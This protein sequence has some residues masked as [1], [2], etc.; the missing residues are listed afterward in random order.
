[1]LAIL[2]A[3]ALVPV[4]AIA[5]T[6]GVHVMPSSWF[7]AAF[8]GAGG[9]LT[10]IAAV[11]LSI[12]AA[13]QRDGRAVLLSLAFSVMATGLLVHAFATP[14][15]LVGMNGLVQLAGA[16]NL[17][18]GGVILAASALPALRR[19]VRV[20]PLLR[21]QV[22]VV[23]ALAGTAGAIAL[24]TRTCPRVPSPRSLP[25]HLVF[26]TGAPLLGR[27]RV[28]RRRA[29]SCSPAALATCSSAS[30]W[31][32]RRRRVRAARYSMMD[33]AGWIAHALSSPASRSS[34]SPP[35]STCATASPRG[36]W[37]ATCAPRTS[38]S[39]RRRSSA[40]ACAP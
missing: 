16:L 35:R 15:W 4:L 34:A 1:M 18:A 20:G 17:P 11:A 28:A 38:S 29:P 23:V 10:A 25:A 3:A 14:F 5:L 7:H 37:S 13:R 32:A 31:S 36:R 26:A 19:P 40:R 39:T 27:P 8:A 22:A 21:I 2:A 12:S 24:S 9:A 30:A 6:A 33:L